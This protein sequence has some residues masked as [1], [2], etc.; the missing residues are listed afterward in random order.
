MEKKKITKQDLDQAKMRLYMIMLQHIGPS[1][2]IGMG[3]LYEQVFGRPWNN[4]INDTRQIRMLITQMK[5]EGQAVMSSSSSTNGGYWIA[6]SGSELD[7]FVKKDK[8][9]ALKILSCISNMKKVSLPELMGQML[10]EWND[11]NEN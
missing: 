5:K 7:A 3:E 1:Q 4:R 2:K 8:L 9:R 11:G 10:I 6:A